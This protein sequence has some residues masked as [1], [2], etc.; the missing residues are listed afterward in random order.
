M[1]DLNYKHLHINL[2][3]FTLQVVLFRVVWVVGI[4]DSFNV[5]SAKIHQK[6]DNP[7]DKI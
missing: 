2:F 6:T 1:W 5:E 7:F 4:Q 3:L